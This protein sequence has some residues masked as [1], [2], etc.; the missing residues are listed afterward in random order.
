[1]LRNV[2]KGYMS[3][4]DIAEVSIIEFGKEKV[5]YSGAPDGFLDPD[6]DMISI[7]DVL[8]ESEP[9]KVIIFNQSRLFFFI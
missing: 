2:L 3:Q 8:M 9:E 6:P 4:Y 1:M 5:W 7:R